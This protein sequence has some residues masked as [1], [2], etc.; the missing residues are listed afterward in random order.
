MDIMSKIEDPIYLLKLRE[1]NDPSALIYN[2]IINR[3]GTNI[4]PDFDK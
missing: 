3:L 2:E 1:R 4:R